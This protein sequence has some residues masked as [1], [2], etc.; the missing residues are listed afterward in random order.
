MQLLIICFVRIY[1]FVLYV[2]LPLETTNNQKF[3]MN[4]CN[5]NTISCYLCYCEPKRALFH[6]LIQLLIP[7]LSLLCSPPALQPLPFLPLSG[8]RTKTLSQRISSRCSKYSGKGAS[9]STYSPVE[10][11]RNPKVLAC[12]VCPCSL[13]GHFRPE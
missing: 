6:I 2:I 4:L 12:R 11:C 9:T 3:F 13:K 8:P 5:F 1:L 10:G 7:M